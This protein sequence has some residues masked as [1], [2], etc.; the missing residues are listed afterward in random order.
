MIFH[1]THLAGCWIIEPKIHVDERGSFHEAFKKNLFEETVGRVDFIQENE[2]SS[3]YGAIRGMHFQEG[4][5]AQAKLLRVC[6][7]RIL[8]VVIDLRPQSPTYRQKHEVELSDQN[9]KQL[10]VP[11][12]FAH[13]YAVLSETATVVY[14]IDAPYRPECEK[15]ISPVDPFFAIDWKI[16]QGKQLI[17]ARDSAWPL[18]Q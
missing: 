12:G 10:F 8:D 9:K 1:E 4:E 7:G 13:G 6:H 18:I 2:A 17:N 11:K 16:E 3:P 5:Y 15:G 14:K